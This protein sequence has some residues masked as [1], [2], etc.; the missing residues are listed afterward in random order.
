MSAAWEQTIIFQEAEKP[1]ICKWR[2][3]RPGDYKLHEVQDCGINKYGP[4]V[5][6][7]EEKLGEGGRV[8]VWAQASLTCAVKHQNRTDYIRHRG[9]K[10]SPKGNLYYDFAL[11]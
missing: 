9:M 7:C 11:A 4:T 6:L 10:Q 2:D 3:L 8:Y 1:E 5:V